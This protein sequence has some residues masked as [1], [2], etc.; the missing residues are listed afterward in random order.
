MNS[1]EIPIFIGIL[2]LSIWIL[3]IVFCWYCYKRVFGK[4]GYQDAGF[5]AILVLIPIVNL[6][7]LYKFV[8]KDWPIQAQIQRSSG[9]GWQGQS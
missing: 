9:P 3:I 6:F 7:V 5:Q 4:A 2:G 8:F 1:P